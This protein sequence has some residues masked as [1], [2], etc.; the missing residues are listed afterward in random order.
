MINWYEEIG[1]LITDFNT[2]WFP[3]IL[4]VALQ[5]VFQYDYFLL[6]LYEKNESLHIV[7]SDF[8]DVRINQALEYL[9]KENY[10]AEAMFRLFS[11]DKLAPG[12]YEMQ[13][14]Q[15]EANKLSR[16]DIAGLPHMEYCEQ[17]EMEYRTLGWPKFLQETCIVG[18][19]TEIHCAA[20]SLYN[21]GLAGTMIDD[22]RNLHA[23]F[24]VLSALLKAYFTSPLGQKWYENSV[25]FLA[26]T[27]K[28]SRKDIEDFFLAEYN[29][30]LTSREVDIFNPLLEGRTISAIANALGVSIHTAKT[31]S[32]NVYNKLG[33]GN[34]LELMNEFNLFK[35]Q[36]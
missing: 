8:Q 34:Q 3:Q 5:K 4:Q 15:R 7:R 12:I 31:H 16:V 32:R 30:T 18:Y 13:S 9:Q 33:H 17:E 26:V 29:V 19:V 6:V 36:K 35:V 23:I 11:A 2:E 20:I 28:T 24:P 25:S 22:T 21:R 10:I 14:L 1:E 27:L